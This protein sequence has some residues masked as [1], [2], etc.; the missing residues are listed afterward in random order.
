[1]TQ[2]E[3][4]IEPEAPA[5]TDIVIAENLQPLEVFG[6]EGGLDPIIEGIKKQV[7]DE[8]FDPYPEET[9]RKKREVAARREARIRDEYSLDH[10]PF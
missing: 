8:V 1:M 7:R 5:S 2:A 3:M 9:E 10:I 4:K 6:K